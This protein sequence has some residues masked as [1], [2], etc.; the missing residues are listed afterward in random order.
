MS[1][2]YLENLA[3]RNEGPEDAERGISVTNFPCILGRQPEG[4]RCLH[5]PLISR[6]HCLLFV[7]DGD[8]WVEDLKS[9]NGS[10]LNAQP[11][12][13]AQ[14]LD[15]GDLLT[16]AHLSFEV[17]L[18]ARQGAPAVGPEE[19][20]H[21]RAGASA[22]RNVLV[23]DDDADAAQSLAALLKQWG[24]Q[25]RV[26]HDGPQALELAQN[27]PP[28]TVLLDIRLPGMDGYQ[29]AQRL[30]EQNGLDKT[31]VVAITGYDP[32]DGSERTREAGID[33]L[34]VKPVTPE[35]LHEVLRQSE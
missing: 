34:L 15:N 18:P 22:R 3:T 7:Q 17:H 30:R 21:A 35:T 13:K 19:L 28:D 32:E 4:Y 2:I 10:Y 20:V 24:H 8:V 1:E 29:V 23:V 12:T 25:V 33:Q 27:S 6:R 14:P 31:H 9:R 26:A 5:H 11:L 16:M